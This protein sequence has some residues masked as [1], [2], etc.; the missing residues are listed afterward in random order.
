MPRKRPE[1]IDSSLRQFGG[2]A[3]E[4][5]AGVLFMRTRG[6]PRKSRKSRHT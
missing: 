5:T 1:K 4:R 6:L 2:A 3:S